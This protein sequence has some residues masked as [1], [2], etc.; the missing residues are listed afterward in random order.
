MSLFTKPGLSHPT[1][2]GGT[3]ICIDQV[4]EGALLIGNGVNFDLT[5]LT[6][7]SGISITNGAGT[8]L[9]SGTAAY[10]LP[11][12]SV[13]VLGGIKVGS[14]LSITGDGTL[15]SLFPAFPL[16]PSYGGTGL[17]S[18]AASDGQ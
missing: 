6:A 2:I 7:G 14:G 8:I 16:G 12:A 5:T 4:D 17:D 10:S 11:I 3:G 1:T 18:S 9:I 13:S 15:S